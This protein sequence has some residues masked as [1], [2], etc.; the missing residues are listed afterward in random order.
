MRTLTTDRVK[1]RYMSL[2]L[3]MKKLPAIATEQSVIAEVVGPVT[4]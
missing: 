2:N 1:F 3:K 4:V